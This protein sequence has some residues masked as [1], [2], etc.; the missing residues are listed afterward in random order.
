MW[1]Q[2]VYKTSRLKPE[3]GH[4]DFEEIEPFMRYCIQ[5]TEEPFE[6]IVRN[7][8]M[9]IQVVRTSISSTVVTQVC[10]C[11]TTQMP[12]S[13]FK[14][15][16]QPS[17]VG[18]QILSRGLTIEGLATSFFGR[19]AK[20]PRA[21]LSYRWVAGLGTKNPIWISFQFTCKMGCGT[22]SAR[23]RRRIVIFEFKSKMLSS[24]TLSQ[25]KSFW[26]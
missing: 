24:R 12:Q 18:G 10:V 19:T 6:M 17:I 5:I 1:E 16:K 15:R 20:M 8:T 4:L 25:T 2:Q 9:F 22:F 23:L 7:T 11:I 13:R 14:Q 21:I 3:R 26:N